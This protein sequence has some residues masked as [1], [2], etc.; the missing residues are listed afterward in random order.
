MS[1]ISVKSLS[2]SFPYYRKASG[3][4]ASIKNLWS[5]EEHYKEVVKSL[6]FDIE[7]GEIVAFIGPNGA[8]KT[9]TMKM[10]SGILHPTS[11]QAT[12]MG[13]TPWERQKSFKMRFSIV[14]GQKQQL[15]SDLPAIDSFEL[16]KRIYEIEETAFNNTLGELSEILNVRHLL[17]IQVRRLSLGERMKMELIAAMLHRPDVIFLDEPTLGLDFLSQRAILSF[18]KTLSQERQTTMLLT[19]HNM[20]DI[21]T[22]CDR[23]LVIQ[24]GGLVYSGELNDLNTVVGAKRHLHIYTHSPVSPSDFKAY[25]EIVQSGPNEIIIEVSKPESNAILSKILTQADVADINIKEP[26]LD[27]SL[28]RLYT[29]MKVSA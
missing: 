12:I 16:N 20:V 29:T 17:D 22:L 8:G 13:Y 5:R 15:W 4:K 9:T 7:Q 24:N 27:D 25:G 14:M 3:L 1:Y 28:Q 26:P 19:S 6:S 23:A 2:K 18:L 10:L 21:S 11:G